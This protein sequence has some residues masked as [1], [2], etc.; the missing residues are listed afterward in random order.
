LFILRLD[1]HLLIVHIN[2]YF[3]KYIFEKY[4]YFKKLKFYLI[5][6]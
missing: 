4:I 1:T 2:N 3:K 6:V 5:I